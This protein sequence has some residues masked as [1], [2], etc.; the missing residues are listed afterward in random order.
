M[1]AQQIMIIILIKLNLLL[2]LL[3]IRIL[4]RL[5]NHE[6]SFVSFLSDMCYIFKMFLT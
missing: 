5:K 2:T 3:N 1:F 6:S 4:Y